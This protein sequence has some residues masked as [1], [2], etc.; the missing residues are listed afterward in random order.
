VYSRLLANC[1]CWQNTQLLAGF[2]LIHY[3]PFLQ[4]SNTLVS[5]MTRTP[6]MTLWRLVLL[7]L[8]LATSTLVLSQEDTMEA[9]EQVDYEQSEEVA[10]EDTGAAEAA[11]RAAAEAQR[12]AEQAAAAAADE[13]RGPRLHVPTYMTSVEC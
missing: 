6:K 12:A 1:G 8:L 10:E 5:K 9:S 4:A 7:M 11:A 3:F 2:L 13:V